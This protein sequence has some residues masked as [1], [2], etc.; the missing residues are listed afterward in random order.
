MNLPSMMN[1]LKRMKPGTLI[2]VEDINYWRYMK[3]KCEEILDK[4]VIIFIGALKRSVDIFCLF[5]YPKI[6]YFIEIT[7]YSIKVFIK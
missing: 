1:F 6:D 4:E 2:E 3:G 7:P 5:Y